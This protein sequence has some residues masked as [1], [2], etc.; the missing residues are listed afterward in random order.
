VRLAGARM[1][2]LV[3]FSMFAGPVAQRTATSRTCLSAAVKSTVNAMKIRIEQSLLFTH[4]CPKQPEKHCPGRLNTCVLRSAWL[5]RTTRLP[6]CVTSLSRTGPG[7]SLA[8]TARRSAERLVSGLLEAE[9]LG[10]RR[11][12]DHYLSKITTGLKSCFGHGCFSHNSLWALF[13]GFSL[14]LMPVFLV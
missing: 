2:L 1:V 12:S 8:E 9:L 10:H 7:W 14:A 13:A 4:C 6:I 11:R 3:S 5:F